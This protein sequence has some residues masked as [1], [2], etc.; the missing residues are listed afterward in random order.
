MR[1]F[2]FI[3]SKEV[4]DKIHS[5]TQYHEIFLQ[6]SALYFSFHY[7]KYFNISSEHCCLNTESNFQNIHKYAEQL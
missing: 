4:S 6:I 1:Y 3:N 7:P 5:D 2:A